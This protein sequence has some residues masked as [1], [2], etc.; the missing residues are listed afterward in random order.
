MIKAIKMDYEC[1]YFW[2][3]EFKKTIIEKAIIEK[4]IKGLEKIENWFWNLK[5]EPQKTG[6]ELTIN[7]DKYPYKWI[8]SVDIFGT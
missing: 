5:I 4:Y 2:E 7:E 6:T 3:N 1:Q 8:M